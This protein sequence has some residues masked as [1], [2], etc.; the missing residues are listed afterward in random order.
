MILSEKDDINTGA[1]FQNI[2]QAI[3]IIKI[4]TKH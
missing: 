4:I 3:E 1:C 2:P